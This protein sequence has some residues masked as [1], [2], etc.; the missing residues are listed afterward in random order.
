MEQIKTNSVSLY[1][2][3]KEH[4]KKYQKN[5]YANDEV[6]RE[7]MKQKAIENA[8]KRY[9]NDD[10]YKKYRREYCNMRNH[11]IREELNK[12]EELRNLLKV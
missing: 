5:R 1:D 2:K 6:F 12:L 3:Q 8:K 7:K 10:E 9:E 11:K 4:I